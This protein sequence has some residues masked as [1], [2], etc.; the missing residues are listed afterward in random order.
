MKRYNSGIL[1]I[2]LF[3]GSKL[4]I[5]Q[6][7]QVLSKGDKY[8]YQNQFADAIE[9][10]LTDVHSKNKKISENAW[11]KLADCYRIT[12]EF[13]KAEATYKKIV[14]RK[15]KNPDSYMNYGL[16]LK[17]SAKFEEAK[18]QFEEYIKLKPSDPMG[19]IYLRSCDSAQR[20]LDLTIGKEVKSLEA[21]N[22]DQSEFSPVLLNENLFFS[23]S[24]K[25]SKEALISLEGGNEIHRMDI[26]RTTLSGLAN[27]PISKGE[28]ENL[29]GIN[30]AMHEASMTFSKDGNEIYF[31]RTVKGKRDLNT[32]DILNSLQI[33]YSKKDST[34]KWSIPVCNFPFNTPGYSSGHPA[35]SLDGNTLYFMSDK[36]GGY[37][38]TDIY[39]CVKELNGKWG[40]PV[41]AGKEVNTF[42]YELFPYISE[43]NILYFSSNSHPGMGQ[44]DIFKSELTNGSWT[45]VQNLMPPI[46]SIGNDFGITFNGNFQQGFFSSD[47]FNG[48]GLED[49]YSFSY[50]DQ[51]ELQILNDTVRFRDCSIFDDQK[52]RLTNESDSIETDMASRNGYFRFK[53]SGEKIFN[54]QFRKNGFSSN[55]LRIKAYTDSLSQDRYFELTTEKQA[56]NIN[57]N[58]FN[59]LNIEKNLTLAYQF[60]DD[61]EAIGNYIILTPQGNNYQ[62]KETLEPGKI[63]LIKLTKSRAD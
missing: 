12:G 39:Y 37:G 3:I 27:G 32:N 8:F 55:S 59:N 9:C 51:F 34:G 48:K 13:E 62:F 50:E 35:I 4:A 53:I 52:F 2:I 28:L 41:N 54:L 1:F 15:K 18:Q 56:V 26:Y 25:G 38:N 22:T 24:R 57:Y 30:T 43:N 61:G 23:S 7:L 45:N 46:N 40:K 33:F 47:R 58:L 20:W 10:Y 16:S 44:L 5:A 42:G 14:K 19:P 49:I 21:I 36:K 29:A 11:L 60:K 63:L 31:T 17:N 6:Q